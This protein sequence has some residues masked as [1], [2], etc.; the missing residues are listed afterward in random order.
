MWSAIIGCGLFK[1][2]DASYTHYD[3][4]MTDPASLDAISKKLSSRMAR[5]LWQ[6]VKVAASLDM[7]LNGEHYDEEM[8]YDDST[9]MHRHIFEGLESLEMTQ[10]ELYQEL[11]KQ[12][13]ELQYVELSIGAHCLK[14]TS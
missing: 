8:N 12:F 11:M 2:T 3:L 7:D 5:S 1:H 4:R 14:F 9:E 13:H 10:P 6:R